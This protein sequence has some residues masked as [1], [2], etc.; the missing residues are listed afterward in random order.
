MKEKE[1]FVTRHSKK[2]KGEDIESSDYPGISEKGVELAKERAKEIESF[3]EQQGAGA[4]LFIGGGSEIPR[5]KSTAEAYGDAIKELAKEKEDILVITKDEIGSEGAPSG[6][7]KAIEKIAEKIKS[8][9]DKKVVIDYPFFLK[10]LSPARWFDEK[11]NLS[12]Y[13]AELLKRNDGNEYEM[14]KDWIQ[15]GGQIEN[16]QGPNPMA[17][18]ESYKHALLRLQKFAERFIEGRPVIIGVVGH[19]MDIDVFATQLA[20]GK[21]DIQGFEEVT[22]GQ[23]IKETEMATINIDEDKI[24]LSYR[25]RDF[26]FE[27]QDNEPE[28]PNN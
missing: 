11:G 12:P 5:T 23:L 14:T 28:K 16:L 10:E 4:V 27:I 25:N 15:T 2:P 8:N 3:L 22:Q 13:A 1:F 7:T 20:K 9:P 17:V 18:A 26:T 6:Y 24:T 21:I 19:S